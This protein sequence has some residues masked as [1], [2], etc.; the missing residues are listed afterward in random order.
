[1]SDEP[2][3]FIQEADCTERAVVLKVRVP[4]VTSF[5]LVGAGK[6]SSGA[7]IV[8][9]EERREAWGG[10]LPPGSPRQRAREEAL[11]GA[12]VVALGPDEAYVDQHGES[13]VVRAQ[14]GRVVVTD[15]RIPEDARPFATAS[16]EERALWTERGRALLRALADDAIEVRRAEVHKILDRALDRIDRRR[17]AVRGDLSKIGQADTIASQAQWL[18]AEAV[19][20]PRGATK[21]VVTDW[22]TGEAVPMVVPLDPSKSAK[23]QVDA[24][25]KRAKRLRL[26][27]RIAEERLAQADLQHEAVVRVR[28]DATA[29]AS[30]ADIDEAARKAKR[31][32]PR[33]VVLLLGD[34]QAIATGHKAKKKTPAT[35]IPYRTFIARSGR[36][37]LVGKG[38]ADNDTLTLRIARP[39]DLWAHAKDRTGAH[40][41][42]QLDKGQTCPAPDLV[43]AAHLAAHFSEAR[44]EKVVDVQYVDRR[45]VRKP[46]GSPPGLV[47]VEREKVTVLRVEPAVLQ[48]LLEREDI[49]PQ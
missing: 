23:E 40:V 36:K 32:A 38:A 17:T 11:A 42:V 15:A 30:I 18:V 37:I 31:A 13:R 9:N 22:S 34:G 7:G 16:A 49:S 43:D 47:I 48:G 29:A 10:R 46:K 1:M 21:L 35:R 28:A 24:M 3:A 8:S 27:A 5:V 33:D 2:T 41:V 26:G 14:G 25:F 44:E 20:T 4:G 12:R 19:R 39:H 6:S 45:Y